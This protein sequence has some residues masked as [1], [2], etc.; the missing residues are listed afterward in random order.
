VNNT[1][2]QPHAARTLGYEEAAADTILSPEPRTFSEA[3]TQ[4]APRRPPRASFSPPTTSARTTVLP[5]IDGGEHGPVHLVLE[6][7]PRYEPLKI[8]ARAGWAR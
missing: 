3:A 8:L 6:D 5:R 1:I 7:R 2:S 4:L